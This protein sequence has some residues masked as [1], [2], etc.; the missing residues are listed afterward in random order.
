[1]KHETVEHYPESEAAYIT[2]HVIKFGL[3]L[4]AAQAL[5]RLTY[6][7]FFT[8]DGIDGHT[9]FVS[10]GVL[11]FF[12]VWGAVLGVYRLDRVKNDRQKRPQ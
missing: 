6:D 9:I 1:M 12:C 5:V 4:G 11:I 7:H 2:A 3:P 10:A 8:A